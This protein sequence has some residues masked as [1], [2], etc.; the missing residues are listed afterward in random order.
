MKLFQNRNFPHLILY[1]VCGFL[2]NQK[3]KMATTTGQRFI[4]GP[5]DKMNVFFSLS[6]KLE[7]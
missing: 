3:S 6:Q 1:K 7:T 4:T 2:V 5:Y